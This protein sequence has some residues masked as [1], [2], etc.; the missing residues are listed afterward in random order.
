[1]TTKLLR[2]LLEST[3]LF[4]VLGIIF[5]ITYAVVTPPLWG[6]DETTHFSRV[7]QLAHGEVLPPTGSK[8]TY[9]GYIPDTLFDLEHYAVADLVAANIRLTSPTATDILSRKDVDRPNDYAALTA[10]LF[11]TDKRLSQQTSTY[12]PVA[13]IGPIIGTMIADS[14]HASIGQTILLAR[15]GSL[16]LYVGIVG[17]ALWVLRESKLKWLVFSVAL[18]P[19]SLYQASVVTA[20]SMVIGLS[21][22]FISVFL[23]LVLRKEDVQSGA[24]ISLLAIVGIL[25]PLVKLNYLF[26]SF[27]FVLWPNRLFRSFKVA[28]LSKVGSASVMAVLAFMWAAV[29]QPTDERPTSQR[30]DHLRIIPADQIAFVLHHPLDFVAAVIRSVVVNADSYAQ[31]LTSDIGWNSVSMPIFFIFV[32]WLGIVLAVMNAKLE[33][34]PSRN[35]LIALN[36]LAIIGAVSIFGALYVAFTPTANRFVEGVQGRYLIPFLIPISMGLASIMPFEVKIKDKIAPYLFGIVTSSCLTVSVLYY[37]LA[38]Y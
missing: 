37:V 19:Q 7:Y 26:L 34:V 21:L 9:S 2:N 22:L 28:I 33:L 25:L 36:T 18:L 23:R 35:R 6:L 32:L 1:M 31:S 14:F 16:L 20:D 12:S 13:Y 5:G 24:L 17:L 27:G 4:A 8:Q 11:S 30:P 29:T 38:T 15:L 10:K 3:W